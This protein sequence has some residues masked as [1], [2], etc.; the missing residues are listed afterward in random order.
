MR[1]PEGIQHRNLLE[2]NQI[3][4]IPEAR[5][6]RIPIC[7]AGHWLTWAWLRES[8]F[9][10][11]SGA[12]KKALRGKVGIWGSAVGPTLGTLSF[13]CSGFC[14][15]AP[16]QRHRLGPAVCSRT[17]GLC[18]AP[19]ENSKQLL[20]PMAE[21]VQLLS[22][23]CPQR[24]NVAR[25]KDLVAPVQKRRCLWGTHPTGASPRTQGLLLG[26]SR[27]LG[28]AGGEAHQTSP[29]RLC[30]AKFRRDD[31]FR[32]AERMAALPQAGSGIR[33]GAGR[34]VEAGHV[35]FG[36]SCENK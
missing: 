2:P 16:G 13:F 7:A 35:L 15:E 26:L 27:D 30:R 17:Q 19:P 9:S 29:Y 8:Q 11:G 25:R 21:R 23:H 28:S 36:R 12:I 1:H 24:G 18:S 34:R 6:E 5:E 22:C 14:R 31:A 10:S 33:P 20:P 32:Q 4:K 3:P